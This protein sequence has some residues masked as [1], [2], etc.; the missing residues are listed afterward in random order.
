M[1]GARDLYVRFTKLAEYDTLGQDAGIASALVGSGIAGKGYYDIDNIENELGKADD[2]ISTAAADAK[3]KPNNANKGFFGG[4]LGPYSLQQAQNASDLYSAKMQNVAQ[5]RVLG[6]PAGQ[7]MYYARNAYDLGPAYLKNRLTQFLHPFSR[8]RDLARDTADKLGEDAL[9]RRKHY[10]LFTDKSLSPKSLRGHMLEVAMETQH[11]GFDKLKNILTPDVRN[12]LFA[13]NE[14]SYLQ[15]LSK[16]TKNKDYY[17]LRKLVVEALTGQPNVISNPDKAGLAERILGSANTPRYSQMYRSGAG[18]LIK[19]LK[20]SMGAAFLGLGTAGAALLSDRLMRKQSFFQK[21]DNDTAPNA[22]LFLGAGGIGAGAVTMPGAYSRF[23]DSVR[24]P[25]YNLGIT[26]GTSPEIGAGHKE[27]AYAIRDLIKQRIAKGADKDKWLSKINIVDIAR[28]TDNFLPASMPS[29]N[30]LVNTGGGYM[31][32]KTPAFERTTWKAPLEARSMINY[33]TDAPSDNR[34]SFLSRLRAGATFGDRATGADHTLMSWGDRTLMA[35]NTPFNKVKH[36][37]SGMT[38]AIGQ[39]AVDILSSQGTPAEARAN[40][41]KAISNPNHPLNKDPRFAGMADTLTDIL[42]DTEGKR[43]IVVSGSGRG[44]YV[45]TRARLLADEIRKNNLQDQVRVIAQLTNSETL[46]PELKPFLKGYEDVVKP[47]RGWVPKD[48]FVGLQGMADVHMGSSGTSSLAEA[49]ASKNI[50][51]LPRDW[52][53][54]SEDHNQNPDRTQIKPNSFAEHQNRILRETNPTYDRSLSR[55]YP[56]NTNTPDS[57][58]DTNKFLRQYKTHANLDDWNRGNIDYAL[59][60]KG[61]LQADTAEDIIN[62]IK[63]PERLKSLS[64]DA[65]SRGAEELDKIMRGREDMTDFI[66]SKMQGNVSKA[67]LAAGGK[68]GLA[69]A[70]LFGGAAMLPHGFSKRPND[71]WYKGVLPTFKR[72]EG[73]FIDKLRSSFSA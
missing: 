36:V 67:R 66:L 40:I 60:Q 46:N 73:G 72:G 45:A 70:A 11:G 58:A 8:Y 33:M 34:P 49:L 68:L 61:V 13:D 43:T 18:N 53:F 5:K 44:D 63:D 62:L 69:A 6:M 65:S 47:V 10:D 14:D 52:G 12:V 24:N 35:L 31:G 71:S 4:T 39:D 59:A 23:V 22:N 3:F 9:S 32:F 50:L 57:T 42:K 64:S 41:A 55:M 7:A 21:N 1:Q 15:R 48:L 28:D 27:P 56:V 38:P 51:A 25:N 20:P 29:L 2:T 19:Y 54:F 16:L 26:Y 30:T 17:T 37:G